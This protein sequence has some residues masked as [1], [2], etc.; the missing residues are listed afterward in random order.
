MFNKPEVYLTPEERIVYRVNRNRRIIAELLNNSY[1][2]KTIKQIKEDFVS[3]HSEEAWEKLLKRENKRRIVEL[4]NLEEED[5][6]K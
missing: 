2:D 6:N 1:E 3:K 5:E 4:W